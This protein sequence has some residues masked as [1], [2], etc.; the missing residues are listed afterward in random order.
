VIDLKE[1]EVVVGRDAA[2]AQVVVPH[3]S[4]S[5]KHAKLGFEHGRFVLEDLGSSNGTFVDGVRITAPVP[6]EPQ[7]AVTFGTVD[8]LFV[9]RAPEAGGAEG[10]ADP[11]AEVLC[12]HAVHLGK[13]TEQQAREALAEHRASG[14]TLGEIFVTKG[15]FAPREWAEVYRH[16]ATI[17]TLRPSGP[18]RSSPVRTFG[19][20]VIVLGLAALVAVIVVKWL[21]GGAQ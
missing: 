3:Q 13:A 11:H 2:S 18:A 21:G 12:H 6:L 4:V 19:V 16:R 15:V 1:M 7:T 9:A 14:R 20:V 5:S 8:C 10:A 17:A